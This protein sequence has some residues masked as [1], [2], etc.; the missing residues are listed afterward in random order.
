MQPKIYLIGSFHDFR[1]RI[2]DALPQYPFADPRTH[3]QSC[4]LKTLQDD[5]HEAE[6]C[7]I[8]L[9]V[10]PRGKSR[11]VMSYAEIGVSV[12]NG[13][14][15]I[16]VDEDENP[17]PLLR[18]LADYYFT[19]LGDALHFL[20]GN[21]EFGDT[22]GEELVSKY[23]AEPEKKE[24]P[25]E[26]VYF[27]GTIDDR[28]LGIIGRAREARPDKNFI[29]KSGDA[30][31]DFER[32]TDYD[33]IV[34]NFPGQLD[35]DRDACFMLGAAYSHDISVVL[36]DAHDWKYPPLQGLARRHCTPE[37]LLDYLVNVDDLHITEEAKHMYNFFK[38]ER[39][40][41]KPGE[42]LK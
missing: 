6:S 38:A 12:A 1:D 15:L 3:R 23:P 9:A 33:L 14:H 22:A 20:G 36:M 35:W 17:D 31:S 16:I 5:V 30:Y 13:N 4:V 34:V 37:V 10:F 24:I 25:A 11:G 27:C 39:E 41:R 26:T 32:I 18:G 21:P 29:V 28:L 19:D 40:R 8:A 2:I 7:P 42:K